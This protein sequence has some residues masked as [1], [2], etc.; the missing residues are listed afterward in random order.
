MEVD[1][2]RMQLHSLWKASFSLFSRSSS[3]LSLSD[4]CRSRVLRSDKNMKISPYMVNVQ[5]LQ[6]FY[7]T[8]S[9]VTTVIHS[10]LRTSVFISYDSRHCFLPFSFFIFY[11]TLYLIP[12]FHFWT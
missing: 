9:C 2:N 3:S 5:C 6:I 11:F 12:Y 8:Q 10:Y 7:V 4:P 1:L